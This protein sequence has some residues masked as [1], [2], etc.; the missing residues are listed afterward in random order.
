MS[1]T[2]SKTNPIISATPNLSSALAFNLDILKIVSFG[3]ELKDFNCVHINTM[4]F[5][6]LFFFVFFFFCF[7]FWFFFFFFFLGGGG[8]FFL[9][10][11]KL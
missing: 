4:V 7:F 2:L 9:E 8:G 10:V 6:F 1:S 5:F 3:K 11:W